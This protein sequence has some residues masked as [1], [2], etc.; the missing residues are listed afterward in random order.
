MISG[1]RQWWHENY[2][3]HCSNNIKII[4]WNVSLRDDAIEVPFGELTEEVKCEGALIYNEYIVYDT[5]QIRER[6][7]VEF[8]FKFEFDL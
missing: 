3:N 8:D 6:F 2:L 5:R 4:I 7:L 1:N